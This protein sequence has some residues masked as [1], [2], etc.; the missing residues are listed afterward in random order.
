MIT[1][2]GT[3]LLIDWDLSKQVVNNNVESPPERTGTWQF[4]AARL[5]VEPEKNLRPDY[6]DDL[7]SFWHTLL[8]ISLRWCEHDLDPTKVV[9]IISELFDYKT[10]DAAGRPVGGHHK[11]MELQTRAYLKSMGIRSPPLL[12]ILRDSARILASRY[13]GE[14]EAIEEITRLRSQYVG[15]DFRFYL[16]NGHTD[17]FLTNYLDWANFQTLKTSNWMEK[18]FDNVLNDPATD[19]EQG[20]GKVERDLSTVNSNKRKEPPIDIT[21]DM[22]RTKHS[23]NANFQVIDEVMEG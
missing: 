9:H 13:C 22:P 11:S 17:L 4:M 12:R 7:E 16:M 20:Q 10:Q 6:T 3:G 1:E 8:Y 21:I 19:W 2:K 14:E 18:I 23:R 15:N 5:L